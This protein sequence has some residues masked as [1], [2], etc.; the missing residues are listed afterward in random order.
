MKFLP[1]WR[2]QTIGSD[3]PTSASRS[4]LDV[5]RKNRKLTHRFFDKAD[6]QILGPLA[7]R[8]VQYGAANSPSL[9]L[10]KARHNPCLALDI[11]HTPQRKAGLANNPAFLQSSHGDR[12]KPLAASFIENAA[13]R[14]E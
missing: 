12:K 6:S 14:F 8:G 10:V 1:Q 4:H 9:S 3:E 5:A 11:S 13:A 7:Q 2:M